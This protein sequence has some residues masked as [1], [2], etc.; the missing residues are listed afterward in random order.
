MSH[1]DYETVAFED[2]YALDSRRFDLDDEDAR[3]ELHQAKARVAKRAQLG[4]PDR[5]D[6][7]TVDLPFD[8]RQAHI[9]HVAVANDMIV[10]ATADLMLQ[11]LDLAGNVTSCTL[12][13]GRALTMT[14][15]GKVSKK[16]KNKKRVD[17]AGSGG[18]DAV[19][20][21]LLDPLGRH[22]LVSF[23]RRPVL[24]YVLLRSGGAHNAEPLHKLVD[25]V[26]A[27]GSLGAESAPIT[28]W[29]AGFNTNNRYESTTSN[30]L[31]GSRA[32][33]QIWTARFDATGANGVKRIYTIPGEKHALVGLAVQRHRELAHDR[34]RAVIAATP[35][36]VLVFTGYGTP[37]GILSTYVVDTLGK[38][39]Q[40]VSNLAHAADRVGSSDGGTSV[41]GAFGARTMMGRPKKAS[42][43]SERPGATS[44]L[45]SVAEDMKQP[46]IIELA[47]QGTASTS[48]NAKT[49]PSSLLRDST[50]SA[51][52]A[53]IR[54]PNA[55]F[56]D[57]F[58]ALSNG[59]LSLGRLVDVTLPQ[60]CEASLRGEPIAYAHTHIN[61]SEL[62]AGLMPTPQS[63]AEPTQ[64]SRRTVGSSESPAHGP[65]SPNGPSSATPQQPRILSAAAG[66]Y[67]VYLT[68]EEGAWVVAHPAT[69]PWSPAHFGATSRDG[70][71]ARAGSASP[72][73]PLTSRFGA[74][75]GGGGGAAGTGLFS[76]RHA[77][78]S[79]NSL[80][81][82]P[83]MGGDTESVSGMSA[84]R[85]GPTTQHA[86]TTVDDSESQRGAPDIP[87]SQFRKLLPALK[88][89]DLV[90]RTIMRFPFKAEDKALLKK[91]TAAAGGVIVDSRNGKAYMV[92]PF[93]I[94]ELERPKL[95]PMLT[96]LFR[97]FARSAQHVA[98]SH[99]RALRLDFERR[100][101]EREQKA[102]R[103]ASSG[104]MN[105]AFGD[106]DD[107]DGKL[108]SDTVEEQE[109]KAAAENSERAAAGAVQEWLQRDADVA[110]E[111][112]LFMAGRNAVMQSE[113][114]A[115]R[116]KALFAAERY[117][118][119]A[120][121]FSLCDDVTVTDVILLFVDAT[122][123][124]ADP[125]VAIGLQ[126]YISKRVNR[127]ITRRS[128]LLDHS[129]QIYCLAHFL[130]LV[131][132]SR[133]NDLK[134]LD[135]TARMLAHA[136]DAGLMAIDEQ[137]SQRRAH[138]VFGAMAPSH[139][140]GGVSG[141]GATMNRADLGGGDAALTA[142]VATGGGTT[143]EGS[144][145]TS[146]YWN[147]VHR[148]RSTDLANLRT[149]AGKAADFS[150][151]VAREALAQISQHLRRALSQTSA[152][153]TSAEGG[154][155]V[156]A[157]PQQERDARLD[158]IASSITVSEASIAAVLIER[159]EELEV[160]RILDRVLSTASPT[161]VT[162]F[163]TLLNRFEDVMRYL[164]VQRDTRGATR[165]LV[166][167]CGDRMWAPLWR[168]HVPAL[169]MAFP[170][171]I[172]RKGLIPHGAAIGL[173]ALDFSSAFASYDML[174]HNERVLATDDTDLHVF[175]S[176]PTATSD[177]TDSKKSL[178]GGSR[179]VSATD[180]A[181]NNESF[182]AAELNFGLGGRSRAQSHAGGAQRNGGH[183]P[184]HQLEN[185]LIEY[186]RHA[187][188][189]EGRSETSIRD[190][191]VSALA[192]HAQRLEAVQEL[193]AAEEV[194]TEL[195]A[196]CDSNKFFTRPFALRECNR[197][198]RSRAAAHLY[199]SLGHHSDA[200]RAALRIG[201]VD[202]AKVLLRR[203]DEAVLRDRLWRQLA[204][205][206]VKQQGGPKK[207][208]MLLRDAEGHLSMSDVL[209]YFTDDV[210]LVDFR[211]E[212]AKR[213]ADF[214]QSMKTTAREA[215]KRQ[216]L[217]ARLSDQ[218]RTHREDIL[219]I[220]GNSRCEECK[221]PALS[222]PWLFFA[223]C[224][225][226]FHET[227]FDVALE[228]VLE[229][230]RDAGATEESIEEAR[231]ERECFLCSD[232]TICAGIGASIMGQSSLAA[233]L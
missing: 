41:G 22:V 83:D 66:P 197:F 129:Q 213:V 214:Q 67:F 168:R 26:E 139:A 5:I 204:V 183:H 130:V 110:F 45:G 18:T 89:K 195:I 163:C 34:Q 219:S 40:V 175:G 80:G 1:L 194:E 174:R 11:V 193:D 166:H 42:G 85:R 233:L 178:G 191:Y 120:E 92:T 151:D 150:T 121:Q 144:T 12:N 137:A 202:M 30:I 113:V 209:P 123:A 125:D 143:G 74:L 159:G 190:W 119:A 6:R 91:S 76:M 59:G 84:F 108:G 185:M 19:A 221:Q 112:A 224:R 60:R 132:I 179:T 13:I 177:N 225:H 124:H 14:A 17:V 81:S 50:T 28:V 182:S 169:L 160:R 222:R 187:I 162:V 131:L 36:R 52:F 220:D 156:A 211:E 20:R 115:A 44:A 199:S 49:P 210:M 9:T 217:A 23:E 47:E 3:T 71:D 98:Y 37:E 79:N 147:A 65:S 56:P 186:L 10:M 171:T 161:L 61:N 189:V 102:R 55:D 72:G 101:A 181:L 46:Y 148:E 99:A 133:I 16:K 27:A 63:A 53:S 33:G 208:L 136:G 223:E 145:T 203:V 68:T 146:A 201:D 38:P 196:F 157:T 64:S 114:R 39:H 62:E 184:P 207:S 172:V 180:L 198:N 192:S 25:L 15:G 107:D 70:T 86:P 82:A 35:Y 100:R 51:H 212:L 97:S 21:V 134:G 229:R 155:G 206:V 57:A 230:M 96:P 165:L 116:A 93:A 78:V 142:F 7:T 58:V 73:S 158:S 48:G 228:K 140:V 176:Q 153:Q 215:T 200:L 118:E 170:R 69:L 31:L 109:A 218:T 188:V 4:R 8:A 126:S 32:G 29:S 149:A 141:A 173:S 127:W 226:A 205:Y 135:R 167:Y 54:Y 232:R 77:A 87:L 95:R 94:F 2:E 231:G 43:P 111:M 105:T 117:I 154:S 138:S 75:G 90:N 128:S 152:P 88:S 164:L 24:L 216:Q 122:N 106:V 103:P 104:I 227:C